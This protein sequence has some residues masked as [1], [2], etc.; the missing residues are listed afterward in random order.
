MSERPHDEISERIGAQ[1][2]E[3]LVCLQAG[4]L[5]RS[6]RRK[7]AQWL[8]RSPVHVR[9]ML[10]LAALSG[11]LRSDLKSASANQG[12]ASSPDPIA[13]ALRLARGAEETAVPLAK[14]RWRSW[15]PW[16]SA[17]AAC[18]SGTGRARR[19]LSRWVRSPS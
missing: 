1:A 10:E 9:A 16:K 8:K 11:Q 6:E 13:V 17:A 4:E 5:N 7:Y 15:R 2:A 18:L 14:P 19:A 3:W 12:P